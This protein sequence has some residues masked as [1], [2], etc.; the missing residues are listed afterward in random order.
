MS[1]PQPWNL[2]ARDSTGV[3]A[4]LVTNMDQFAG[5][6]NVNDVDVWALTLFTNDPLVQTLINPG[7]AIQLLY[8]AEPVCTG[9]MLSW[10][11]KYDQSGDFVTISGVSWDTW[12]G[13]RL[14][15][16][17]P[18]TT[19]PPYNADAYDVFV[20]TAEAAIIHYV[21]VN[22]GPSAIGRRQVPGL[23]AMPTNL[24]RGATVLGLG[25]WDT[26]LATIQPFAD[27]AGLYFKLVEDPSSVTPA[28]YLVIDTAADL[29]LSARF[30]P[31]LNN[32]QSF[33][34]GLAAPTGNYAYV[35]GQDAGTTRPIEEV[36]DSASVTKWFGSP[37][38]TFVSATDTTDPSTLVQE[39][40]QALV[41]MAEQP[42]YKLTPVSDGPI[43]F[44]RD[45]AL[46]DIVSVLIDNV[47]VP[48][49][50]RSVALTIDSTGVQ[51]VPSIQTPASG[52]A[53][54]SHD[55]HVAMLLDKLHRRL[56]N[57]ER[58]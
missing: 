13:W 43:Q 42:D 9:P 45:W 6:L 26:V 34:Y 37:I 29:T 49:T 3:R 35:G 22:C 20:D 55:E 40:E 47:A 38:E 16:P 41:S 14:T 33:E 21:D 12:L 19:S 52:S 10:A 25:R 57:V 24:G 17:Q 30:S 2:W 31:G 56:R 50:I 5:T 53:L 39:G 18:A 23:G 32:L 54:T 36:E 1:L 7:A 48:N 15:H 11:R 46:G 27:G 8:G 28:F 4:G 44:M 58:A 51:A